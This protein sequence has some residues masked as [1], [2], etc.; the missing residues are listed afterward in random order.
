MKELKLNL[1]TYDTDNKSNP[2][3]LLN[4]IKMP[5]DVKEIN[6][7]LPKKKIHIKELEESNLMQNDVNINRKQ[8]NQQIELNAKEN[9]GLNINP[10][11]GESKELNSKN[12]ERDLLINNLINRNKEINTRDPAKEYIAYSNPVVQNQRVANINNV[13]NPM[14]NL[15][16]NKNNNNNNNQILEKYQIKRD[17]NMMI[18][19]SSGKK[20]E[21]RPKTP[22][23]NSHNQKIE[24][25]YIS[26]NQNNCNIAP[27]NN[28]INR[29][30]PVQVLA[31]MNSNPIPNNVNPIQNRN[32]NLMK[33]DGVNLI[34]AK[35]D[36]GN[37]A[38]NAINQNNSNP[39]N[40]D[41]NSRPLSANVNIQ[42]NNKPIQ[43]NNITPLP[44]K[45]QQELNKNRPIIN[46]VFYSHDR[47]KSPNIVLRKNLNI[48]LSA[49]SPRQKSPIKEKYMSNN[50]NNNVNVN[51]I[52][53]G[54]NRQIM[55]SPDKVQQQ[56]KLINNNR[57]EIQKLNYDYVKMLQNV[58]PKKG[59]NYHYVGNSNENAKALV[60]KENN[61]KINI[62]NNPLANNN[63]PPYQNL[64]SRPPSGVK[65]NGPK[66]VVINQRK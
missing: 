49:N 32:N 13:I 56:V 64:L 20:E 21:A 34:Q 50:Q 62:K 42:N 24:V 46:N 38:N 23:Q 7:R 2:I 3:K 43:Q 10:N 29:N 60:S 40:K 48:P 65:N 44:N 8:M 58:D 61:P 31:S 57:V 25:R 33:L 9:V 47:S 15:N 59:Q 53:L 17:N 27:S 22:V 26:H 41:I 63:F 28:L 52:N 16:L 12:K 14:A 66:I 5:R 39:K 37:N 6:Q 30:K 4:T 11:V 45:I 1:D 54:P 51:K 19:P 36:Y 55:K 18:R 35:I